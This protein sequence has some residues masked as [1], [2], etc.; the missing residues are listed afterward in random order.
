M[1]LDGRRVTNCDAKY[2]FYQNGKSNCKY[3]ITKRP[4]NHSSD[5]ESGKSANLCPKIEKFLGEVTGI[6]YSHSLTST[7]M[8]SAR[9]P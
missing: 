8:P 7:G 5:G 2:P 6:M 9:C 3:F 1:T 4:S